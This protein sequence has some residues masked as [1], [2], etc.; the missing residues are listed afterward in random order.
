MADFDPLDAYNRGLLGARVDPRADELLADSI[1][2]YGGDPNGGSVAFDWGLEGIGAGRLTLTFPAMEAVFPGCL[3]GA[4]QLTGDCVA[5][6]GIRA[7]AGAMCNEIVDSRVDEV[8]GR[9]E[10]APEVAPAGVKDFPLAQESLW[11]WRGYDGDGWVCSEAAK[12]ACE[13]G[14]LIRKNYEQLKIDFSHYTKSSIRVG[15]A[16]APGPAG[17]AETKQH[18]ARTATFLKGREQ[19]RDF[20]CAGAGLFNCSGMG[21]ERTRN[22]Y[23]VSRQV[24]RWMHAQVFIGYDDR[25]ETH[26]IFGQGLV[27]WLNQWGI[28]NTGPRRIHGTDIDIPEG[29]FWALADTIDRCGTI[30]AFSSVAG[31]P[32][33]RHTTYGAL[34]NV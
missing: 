22:Q 16:R 27:C 1:L 8:T 5:A 7:V 26:K 3:P 4:A 10:G 11:M 20:L 12:V 24:G 17:L 15:G 32:R 25:P 6:A 14:F 28:W 30:I 34:G 33:R 2:R 19:V 29:S 9:L 23:G 21:F 13:K 18:V 31:W